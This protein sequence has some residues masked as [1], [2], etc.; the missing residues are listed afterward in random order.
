MARRLIGHAYFLFFATGLFLI[1][2]LRGR[3]PHSRYLGAGKTGMSLRYDVVDWIGGW[4]FEVATPDEI[5]RFSRK[6][7]LVL[8]EL[9]TCGGKHGCNEFVF[10]RH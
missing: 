2:M 6:Y 5:C 1:D 10:E 7:D 3:N 9:V 4:P 8:T